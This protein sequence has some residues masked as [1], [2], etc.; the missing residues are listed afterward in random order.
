MRSLCVPAFSAAVG[1]RLPG[2]AFFVVPSF[3]PARFTRPSFFTLLF[4]GFR[5]FFDALVHAPPGRVRA[6]FRVNAENAACIGGW[7][8]FFTT[9]EMYLSKG[10]Y[11][12][13]V[14]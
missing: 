9:D 6:F 1:E 5:V 3:F 10:E 13:S 12:V 8:I 11:H 2:R 7:H 14:K 4:T